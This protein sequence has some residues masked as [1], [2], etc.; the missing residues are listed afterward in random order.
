MIAF[1]GALAL[2][3]VWRVLF[4]VPASVVSSLV[5]GTSIYLFG[6]V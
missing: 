5:V 3:A 1:Y 2:L 6:G 4:V